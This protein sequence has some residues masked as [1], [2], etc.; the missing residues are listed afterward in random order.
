MSAMSPWFGPN[1]ETSFPNA[2]I[3]LLILL[4]CRAEALAEADDPDQSELTADYADLRRS[5]NS[6]AREPEKEFLTT[7]KH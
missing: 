3:P 4:T 1:P 7:N 5:D 6:K 2:E